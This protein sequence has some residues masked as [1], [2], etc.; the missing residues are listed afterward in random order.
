MREFK[1]ESTRLLDLT[2][3]SI[4]TN[5]DIFLRELI[6]NGS[7]A[8]DKLSVEALQDDSLDRDEF[9]IHIHAD[10]E[11]RT[12]TI[13]DNGIGMSEEGLDC[14]LGTIAYSGSLA[15]K[16]DDANATAEAGADIIGQF[17]IGFYSAFM[18][19][20]HVRVVS[21]AYGSSEAFQWKSD[22]VSGYT[23]EPAQRA[24]RGT[25]VILHVR[26]SDRENNFERYL[27]TLSLKQL[28]QRYSN[29]IRY[30]ISIDMVQQVPDLNATA[31]G[32]T[33][34]V[35]LK[36]VTKR[37]VV[38]SMV[39][40]WVKSEDEVTQ[41]EYV[42]FFQAEFRET[43]EPLLTISVHD[44]ELGYDALLFVPSSKNADAMGRLPEPGPAL[45]SSNVLIAEHCTQLLPEYLGFMRGVVD[46][47]RLPLN[48]SR[49]VLQDDPGIEAICEKLEQR[50]LA[51]LARMLEEDREGYLAFFEEFGPYFKHAINTSYGMLTEDLHDLLLYP[52]ARE[53][54]PI[55]L[56][57]YVAAARPSGP[58][59][60]VTVYYATGEDPARI[61]RSPSVRALLGRGLD[62]LLCPGAMGDEI[63]FQTMKSYKGT[64]FCNVG[65][66][67]LDVTNA[68]ER[69]TVAQA[70]RKNAALFKQLAE[71]T[72]AA[73]TKVIPS[74]RL[75]SQNDAAC[76]LVAAGKLSIAMAQYLQA[77]KNAQGAQPLEYT[78][79]VNVNHRLFR[80]LQKAHT[81]GNEKKVR[82]YATVLAGQA[83]LAEDLLVDDPI[84]FVDAVNALIG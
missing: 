21:R 40:I 73:I 49:E 31:Y 57:E 10:A 16:R 63:C 30:P 36:T 70:A 15:F 48:V 39:P 52:S 82:A 28:V 72:P 76:C 7:D 79:E 37:E 42:E 46:S 77:H 14:N 66:A 67:E 12:L 1:T 55:T 47:K 56:A 45:Y 34:P 35:P 13:S 75:I 61:R 50:V 43:T 65:S 74:A 33:A 71:A 80:G 69:A 23:I 9:G 84:A 4:Y 68:A 19:A 81:A 24:G 29:Y 20:D 5:H 18:V 78:L 58:L 8:L 62:V 26:E 53:E 22:G 59:D 41:E 11:T 51:E 83:M 38:N 17:G 32:S 3:N 6:S 27:D 25:D 60:E 54:R 44:A 2:I 64:E